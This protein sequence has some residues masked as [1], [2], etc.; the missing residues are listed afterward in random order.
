MSALVEVTDILDWEV[1]LFYVYVG[2][3]MQRDFRVKAGVKIK[4]RF[5]DVLI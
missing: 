3:F 1:I 2:L 5:R 4:F